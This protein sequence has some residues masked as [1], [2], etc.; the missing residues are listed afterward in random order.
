MILDDEDADEDADYSSIQY[1]NQ[2]QSPG[3]QWEAMESIQEVEESPRGTSSPCAPRTI[4][5]ADELGTIN[6]KSE[7]LVSKSNYFSLNEL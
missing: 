4:H 6:S 1:Q 3:K 5:S 2:N 7:L